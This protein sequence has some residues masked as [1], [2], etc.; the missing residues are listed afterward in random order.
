VTSGWAADALTSLKLRVCADPNNLPFSNEK[1]QGFEN[2]LADLIAKDLGREIEYAWFAQRRGFFRMTLKSQQ[3]DVVM[4]VPVESE[5]ALTTDPYYRSTYVFVTRRDRN[6]HFTSIADPRLR[7]LKV[8]V[9]IIGDDANN[10]PPAEALA[11]RGAVNN[12]VGY[13]VYG[14]YLT[15]NPTARIVEAVAKGDI[16]VAIVW[17]PQAG[18]F[19]SQ[20]SVPLDIS[21]V[22]PHRDGPLPF[23]FEI[24]LGVRRDDPTFRRQLDGILTKHRADIQRLLARYHVPL[25]AQP[26]PRRHRSQEDR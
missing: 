25:L 22:H 17:G 1:E 5:R 12:I 23:T 21:T 3:C 14:N 2:K 9:Q 10:S 6:L 24:S 4:G 18:Y 26:D 20:Q 19:A 7:K 13:T 15:P 16:D 11:K 8:G